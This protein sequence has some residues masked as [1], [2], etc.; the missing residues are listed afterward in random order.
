MHSRPH[1]QRN[2]ET[3]FSRRRS[4]AANESPSYGQ[5]PV[6]SAAKE[7]DATRHT[8]AKHTP[9][10]ACT[11]ASWDGHGAA[12]KCTAAKATHEPNDA[13]TAT[14]V[15]STTWGARYAGCCWSNAWTESD[16][17][18][19]ESRWSNGQRSVGGNTAKPPGAADD[20]DEPTGNG[21]STRNDDARSPARHD[22]SARG[23]G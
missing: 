16:V 5:P 17:H 7:Y 12:A 10:T 11:A 8:Y 6:S 23:N 19:Y 14:A 1:S 9:A 3:C 15:C 2:D 20:D 21:C 4:T 18:E 13:A 22:R